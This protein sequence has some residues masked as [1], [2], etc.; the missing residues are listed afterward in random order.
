MNDL[1]IFMVGVMHYF[2]Q[3]KKRPLYIVGEGLAGHFVPLFG[4]IL[5]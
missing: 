1:Y 4:Q 5:D 3:Y 2:P